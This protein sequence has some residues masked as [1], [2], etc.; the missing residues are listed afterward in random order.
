MAG[1]GT[2][3]ATGPAPA[4]ASHGLWGGRFGADPA[5]SFAE[6][7]RSLPVDYRLWPHDIRAALAWVRALAGV[8]V[9]DRAEEQKMIAG[10]DRVAERI[11]DGAGVGAADE[12]VHTL[13]ERLLGEE[14]G[15]LAGKLNTGRSRNDQ[16][17]TDLRL[18]TLEA[19]AAVDAEICALGRCLAAQATAG[20]DMFMPGY[21][22][23]QRAQPV[24]WGYVL[25]AHAWPL[26]RDRDRLREATR[27]M[28]DLPLGSGAVA[29]SG[30]DVDRV[31]LKEELGFQSLSANAL[32]ATGD[33][34]FVVDA[35]YVLSMLGMH[36]A[37]LAGELMT[38][39]TAE[40]G[41]V[42]LSD[43]FATGSSLLPQKKNPDVLELVRAKGSRLL[44]NL[45]GLLATL[46]GLPAGYSKDLQEDKTYLFDAVDTILLTLP[47]LRGAVE[48]L[49]P[50]P[51]RM[52]AALDPSLLATDMA[53]LL[54]HRGVPFRE[55]HALVGRAVRAAEE[56]QCPVTSLPLDVA[57]AI[58]RALPDIV[59]QLGDWEA[60]VERRPTVG[61]SSMASL[62]DQLSALHDAFTERA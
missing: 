23:G 43:A 1:S 31:L 21:T 53:D 60:S 58:H 2:G 15:P 33:R 18:W 29:G 9:I 37:R 16:V 8:G 56:L 4:D 46:K 14:I 62:R 6:L 13:V 40:F 34:D 52:A 7:N 19:L 57:E 36:A 50:D 27:R 38:Y 17:A 10:L 5:A 12:D 35:V 11:A 41:F 47:A 24:R 51:T 32:D 20:S 26:A 42:K 28:S 48:T 54:V 3:M 39:C 61:G 55:A 59:G 25:A 44:A 30:L 45:T 49:T 22:H